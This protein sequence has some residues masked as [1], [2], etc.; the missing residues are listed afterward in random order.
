MSAVA[1]KDRYEGYP[2]E[3]ISG[4][5]EYSL[6][7]CNQMVEV[8]SACV[9]SSPNLHRRNVNLYNSPRL[10]YFLLDCQTT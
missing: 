4:V 7:I 5:L 6:G 2:N 8:G 3:T 9:V 10:T 1:Y